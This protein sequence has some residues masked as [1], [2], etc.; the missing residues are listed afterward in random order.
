MHERS[1]TDTI[2]GYFYQFDY[3]II[4]LLELSND[5]DSIVIEGIEDVD[6]KTA[7]DETAVQCKYYAKT[8]YNHSEIAKPIRLMLNNYKEAKDG[9]KRPVNYILYGHF[10]KGQEK[11]KLPIDIAFLK[12][13]FLTYKQDDVKYYHHISLGLTDDDLK[14]F[15]SKLTININAIDYE[16]QV[17]NVIE[18]LENQFNCTAFEAENF[19][20]NN[21]LKE[22]KNIAVNPNIIER[23]ITKIDF[24]IKINTRKILF[25]EWFIKFKS[26]KKYLSEFR[27]QYFTTLNI[28]PFERFFFI[29]V[30]ATNYSRSELKEL[31]FIISKKWSKTSKRESCPFCPYVY[32]HNIAEQELIELKKEL[33]SEEFFTIDGFDFNGASFSPKSISRAPN[34]GNKIK[35]KILNN[36]E[37]TKLVFDAISKPKEVYEFYKTIPFF[38]VNNPSIKHIR[39]PIEE[40]SDIKE[41]I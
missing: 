10:Q 36:I 6:I 30:P 17:S 38:E 34:E 31:L 33:H 11:L 3:S 22:I 18:L 25:N 24:L 35:L 4:K 14:S 27:K 39:I 7:T 2:K 41:V 15:L 8:E 16:T 12:D 28:S 26:K 21:A 40:L 37:Y 1:A 32:L 29:E 20:Y 13:K 9:H 5:K 23:K 19:Y